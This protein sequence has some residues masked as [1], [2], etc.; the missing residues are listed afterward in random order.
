MSQHCHAG[1]RSIAAA[2]IMI[3]VAG[4]GGGGSSS[5]PV[6][7]HPAATST[8]PPA[9]MPLAIASLD[10]TTPTSLTALHIAT[11]G[12]NASAPVTVTFTTAAGGTTQ[13]TAFRVASDGTVVV[14]VPQ[15]LDPQSGA[16]TSTPATVTITQNGSTSAPVALTILDTPQISD[17]GTTTG[18]ISRAFMNWESLALSGELGALQSTSTSGSGTTS[19]QQS[20]IRSLLLSEIEARNDVDRVVANNASITIGTVQGTP[21]TFNAAAVSGMDRALGTVLLQLAPALTNGRVS[22]SAVRSALKGSVVPTSQGHGRSTTYAVRYPSGAVASATATTLA[23]VGAAANIPAASIGL[24][25]GISGK[26]VNPTGDV[27][28]AALQGAGAVSSLIALG[29]GPTPAGAAFELVSLAC[30]LGSMAVSGVL[31][32][33]DY[34]GALDAAA[35]GDYATAQALS[36]DYSNQLTNVG[37]SG[38]GTV[39]SGV[40]AAGTGVAGSQISTFPS[41]LQ[42]VKTDPAQVAFQFGGFLTTAAGFVSNVQ[43]LNA[44]AQTAAT[45]SMQLSNAPGAYAELTG[46]ATVSNAQGPI[47]SGLTGV[48]LTGGATTLTSG[49]ADPTGAYLVDIPV[50]ASGVNYSNLTLQA[51]DP[52]SNDILSSQSVNVRNAQTGTPTTLPGMSGSCNDTDAGSPDADDPD[53]D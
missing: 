7:A 19:S 37:L 52:V 14:G 46:Q 39:L 20:S 50:G 13:L 12:V 3:T 41:V 23:A 9:A 28:L 22:A 45:V 36:N 34:Q 16:T 44:D 17:F 31:A 8:T 29:T 43:Q 38:L 47:L 32:Y 1:V 33:T 27:I 51:T 49:L 35:R 21:V 6:P 4:C 24:A 11:T 40:T 25:Q 30:S 53:C 42:V 2:L 15:Y 5:A 48:S 18:Q 26:S 10:N